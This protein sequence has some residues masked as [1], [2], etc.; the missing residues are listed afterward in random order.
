[1]KMSV[2]AAPS[3]NPDGEIWATNAHPFAPEGVAMAVGGANS[4]YADYEMR[5]DNSGKNALYAP[6]NWSN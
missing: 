6:F 3:I 1:M 2:H 4:T 5:W